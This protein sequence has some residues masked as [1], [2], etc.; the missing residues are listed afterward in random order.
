MCRTA[1]A[2]AST[3]SSSAV[4][5]CARSFRPGPA[6]LVGDTNSGRRGLD[7]EVPAFNGRE[8]GWIDALDGC[9]WIDVFRHWRA[10]ARAYTW[11]SPFTDVTASP[12][13]P[14]LRQPRSPRLA[15]R[16]VEHRWGR[17]ALDGR[18][19]AVSDHAALVVDLA[20]S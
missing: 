9:G 2:G 7:E 6:L 15:S 14:S 5:V 1:S 3:R 20:A 12:D 4:L 8:E 13:R 10:E 11:Y 18:R 17:P 19:D 16:A